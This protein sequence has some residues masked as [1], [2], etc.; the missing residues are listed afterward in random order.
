VATPGRRTSVRPQLGAKDETDVVLL[1]EGTN[2]HLDDGTF[3][4]RKAIGWALC[5]YVRAAAARHFARQDEPHGERLRGYQPEPDGGP[6]RGS[7]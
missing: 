1:L 6:T 4:L 2:H 5:D 3:G 7:P